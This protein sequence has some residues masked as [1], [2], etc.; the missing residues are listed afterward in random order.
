MRLRPNCHLCLLLE[1]FPGAEN[2]TSSTFPCPWTE[3]FSS[4]LPGCPIGFLT[5]QELVFLKA[6]DLRETLMEAPMSFI[7]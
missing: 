7:P 2:S 5:T 3:H 4:L 6:R 1:G